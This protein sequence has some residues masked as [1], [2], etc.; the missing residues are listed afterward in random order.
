MMPPTFL[1]ITRVAAVIFAIAS[2]SAEQHTIRFINQC[3]YGTSTL[4]VQGGQTLST[5]EDYV[6]NGPFSAGIA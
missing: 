2:V 4:G 6:S 1:A 3:G 5:G